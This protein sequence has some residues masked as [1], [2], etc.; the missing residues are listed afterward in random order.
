MPGPFHGDERLEN[1]VADAPETCW[2]LSANFNFE[3]LLL[4]SAAH[5][6]FFLNRADSSQALNSRFNMTRLSLPGSNYNR[7][8]RDH[9]KT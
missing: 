8:I 5:F 3:S 6:Q 2:P 1:S 9:E 4:T 7:R